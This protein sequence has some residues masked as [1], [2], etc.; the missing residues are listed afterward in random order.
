MISVTKTLVQLH[1]AA[2]AELPSGGARSLRQAEMLPG[3]PTFFRLRGRRT[4]ERAARYLPLQKRLKIRS[5]R[6]SVASAPFTRPRAS[7]AARI[8]AATSSSPADAEL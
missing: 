1:G 3:L 2:L 5:S 6:S 7:T 8:S 4:L